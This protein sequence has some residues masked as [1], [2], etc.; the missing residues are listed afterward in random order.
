MNKVLEDYYKIRTEYDKTL[1]AL[2]KE[3]DRVVTV[4]LK[5]FKSKGWYDYD[6]YEDSN[7][8]PQPQFIKDDWFPCFIDGNVE[9]ADICYSEG[10]PVK[11]FD[12][13][14]KE[15]INYLNNEA[16]DFEQKQIKKNAKLQQKKLKKELEKKKIKRQAL[17]KLAIA[18]LTD[19]EKKILNLIE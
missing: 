19:E 11:F 14:D 13:T 18:N 10:F 2:S 17:K 4:I 7:V 16:Y 9:H 15:I 1:K 5:F 6:Y 8:R 12:M 3:F